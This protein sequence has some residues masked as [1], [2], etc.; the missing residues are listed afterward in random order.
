MALLNVMTAV[1]QV[2][3]CDLHIKHGVV[4]HPRIIMPGYFLQFSIC[5]HCI[6]SS[7]V[8]HYPV[9]VKITCTCTNDLVPLRAFHV[10]VYVHVI[11][12]FGGNTIISN[13]GMT[14]SSRGKAKC[15]VYY[16]KF[17]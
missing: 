14:K 2:P 16:L 6:H 8:H 12:W 17:H 15:S 9:S 10:F 13:V 4:H 3:M 1:V 5:Q 11:A 7:F